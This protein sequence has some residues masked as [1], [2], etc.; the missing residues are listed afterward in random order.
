MVYGPPPM[1]LGSTIGG[2]VLM[3][4]S[5]IAY[6]YPFVPLQSRDESL[7]V[8]LEVPS[9]IARPADPHGVVWRHQ[10][11]RV[12]VVEGRG[13]QLMRLAPAAGVGIAA[14]EVNVF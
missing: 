5:G 14:H 12:R 11:E 6:H 1:I 4:G 2:V 9:P 8:W 13:R 7:V 3:T 10:G